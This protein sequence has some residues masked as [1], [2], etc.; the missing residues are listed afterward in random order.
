MTGVERN[1]KCH[2]SSRLSLKTEPFWNLPLLYFSWMHASSRLNGKEKKKRWRWLLERVE[3]F[4]S[5]LAVGGCRMNT[6]PRRQWMVAVTRLSVPAKSSPCSV[7][8]RTGIRQRYSQ[9]GANTKHVNVKSVISIPKSLNIEIRSSVQQRPI[10]TL[11]YHGCPC[12]Q[13][14]ITLYMVN[15]PLT[16]SRQCAMFPQRQRSY[17]NSQCFDKQ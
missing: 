4:L 14:L 12:T 16:C 8:L 7:C 17:S 3:C 11:I 15:K 5:V 13:G 6:S 1:A 9:P 2:T 10:V